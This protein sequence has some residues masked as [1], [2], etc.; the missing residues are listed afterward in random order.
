ML[1]F[2]QI[3]RMPAPETMAFLPQRPY[4]PLGTL[5]DGVRPMMLNRARNILFARFCRCTLVAAAIDPIR[6]LENVG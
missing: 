6:H 3:T 1:P 4:L 5:R 2:L